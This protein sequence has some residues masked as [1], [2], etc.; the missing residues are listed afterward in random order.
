[1]KAAPVLALL[2]SA[3]LGCGGNGGG[4]QPPPSTEPAVTFVSV[5][6]YGSFQ[7]LTGRAFNVNPA[8]HGVAVYIFVGGWWTKPYADSRVTLIN[9][10]GSWTCDITTGG[11]DEQA[12]RIAAFLIPL[13][14]S[15]P[16]VL[17]SASLPSELAANALASLEVIRDN[18]GT[19]RVVRFAGYEWT[20][21]RSV[22]P[23]GPPALG[24]YFSDS[25]GNVWVD[26]QGRLHL[27]I[28]QS[29]GRWYCAE[30][31]CGSSLGCGAYTF[32]LDTD[33]A[34]LNE[35]VV[36]GLFTWDNDPEYNHREIDIE[37][38]RWGQPGAQN[39]QY[40]VQPWDQTG[41]RYR[42]FY[43]AGGGRSVHR[44]EWRSSGVAFS[45]TRDSAQVAS[46]TY[47]GAGVPPPGGESPRINLW[48]VG[49]SSAPPSDGKEVEVILS[50]F[51]FAP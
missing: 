49:G 45:S 6:P 31:I 12:T 34:V 24:N 8:T 30:V 11:I 40:V 9:P 37:F 35:N 19:V 13:A 14:Y 23:V 15:P 18:A 48:L 2:I 43:P 3:A 50:S 38:S 39:A 51:N 26:R 33:P 28:T 10:D 25:P 47:S 20:V 32:T 41:H 4:V 17:G 22:I 16:V 29:E 42:F 44:F 1:M 46:W 21:K 27:K 7:N 5:P 36:L